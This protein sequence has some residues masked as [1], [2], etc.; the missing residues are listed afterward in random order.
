MKIVSLSLIGLITVGGCATL[1][2]GSRAR[3]SRRPPI[4]QVENGGHLDLQVY[5]ES[6]FLGSTAHAAQHVSPRLHLGR[7]PVGTRSDFTIPWDLVYGIT[8]IRF[9]AYATNGKSP[10]LDQEF[11]I[12]APD[13]VILSVPV[14]TREH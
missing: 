6:R 2:S 8:Q 5:A 14:A 11:I 4:V 3:D 13:T 12:S 9:V 7:A 1:L 10:V